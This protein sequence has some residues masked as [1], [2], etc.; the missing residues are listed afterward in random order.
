VVVLVEG[1]SDAAALRVLARTWE[2]AE[3]LELVVLGGATNAAR[4]ARRLRTAYDRPVLVG[5][6]DV[7]EQRF[8][9]RV[10]P[11]LDA[12][13]VC[14][15]DLEDELFRAAGATGVLDTIEE[16]GHGAAWQTFV[17]QP[18]WRGRP[19]DDQLRRFAGTRSR[20]K[21]L[22]AERIAHRLTRASTPP[23]LAD[24]LD[25]VAAG[26]SDRQP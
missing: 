2:V 11:P 13:L 26:A 1:A 25:R 6:C 15:R 22:L 23:V 8:L 20:R 4:E 9:D 16:L 12:V 19:L 21:E 10:E 17:N 14:D 7:R 24:L 18:E 5:L 3:E